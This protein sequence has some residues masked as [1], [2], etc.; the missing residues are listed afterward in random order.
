MSAEKDTSSAHALR[1][2][3]SAYEGRDLARAESLCRDVLKAEPAN[4]D[5]LNLLGLIA[6]Q[7]GRFDLSAQLLGRALALLPSNPAV[8]NNLG[9]ALRQA[10]RLREAADCYRQALER[11]PDMAEAHNNFGNALQALGRLAEA[12][13]HC[14]RAIALMPAYFEAYNNLGNVLSDLGRRDEAERCYRQ[15]LELNPGYA[16][17]HN[18]LGAALHAAGR[19]EEAER[20]FRQALALKPR[21]ADAHNNLGNALLA[22]GRPQEAEKCYREAFALAQ[23]SAEACNNL[24]TALHRLGRLEEAE[25]HFRRALA[26]RPDFAQAH[27]NLGNSLRERG[28]PQE[29]EAHCRR[30][31]E[32][33]PASAEAHNNLGNALQELGRLEEAEACYRRA[34]ALNARLAEVHKNLAY[35]LLCTGRLEEGFREYEW[36]IKADHGTDYLPDPREGTRML[37]RPTALLPLDW[38][39]KRVFLV[40]DQGIG[41]HLFFLRF[42]PVLR[43][44]GA[45]IALRPAARLTALLARSGWVDE[46]VPET[47]VPE[48]FDHAFFVCDLALLAGARTARAE[49]PRLA[50]LPERLE[51]MRARLAAFG[52]PPWIGVTWRAGLGRSAGLR[53][54]TLYKEIDPS[55][56]GRTLAPLDARLVVLQ[57]APREDELARFEAGLGRAAL[58]LSA[59]NED[60]EGMCALLALLKEYVGVSNTNMHLCA[61][62]GRTA[63]VLVPSPPEWRWMAQGEESPWF[64]GFRIYRQTHG[65]D[66]TPALD[67]LGAELGLPAGARAP[68]QPADEVISERYRSQLEK[69]HADP[70]F[71]VAS[72][73]YAPLVASLINGFGVTELLDYGSGKGRLMQ[74]LRGKVRNTVTIRCYDPAIPEFSAPPQ[75]MQMVACI[76]V[77]EHVEPER[78][79]AVLEELQRCTRRLG[80]FSV[81]TGPAQKRLEDGRNAHLIQKPADWW[82]LKFVQRFDVQLFR[83][84]DNG[85]YVVVFPRRRAQPGQP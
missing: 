55:L 21:Y 50:A 42:A 82:L 24:G 78:L 12:E 29:A 67:A 33:N 84:L 83:K 41:D 85:L 36:R 20:C 40:P 65:R 2:A 64:P 35:L 16:E 63:R 1:A 11:V 80:F 79:E 32:L 47:G 73:G 46:L 15:A 38:R 45:R 68:A 54:P 39:G 56:L 72:V 75:P 69:L 25:E 74:A 17:A 18:N 3:R 53:A 60:L 37:P 71:G 81:H 57:R 13:M 30:S 51:A 58:D 8:L 5:A 66:W 14:R 6:F 27:T 26:L 44:A 9:N 28:R 62:L 70:A 22:A 19:T 59:A 52:P 31:L 34:L 43:A 4:A 76:D 77:L 48:R 61:A 7:A 23:G 49:C 10:G